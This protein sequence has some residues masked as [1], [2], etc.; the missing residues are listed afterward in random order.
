MKLLTWNIQWGCG[1]DGRVDLE[2]IV[3]TARGVADFD[4]FC[5]QEV[6]DNGSCKS[7]AGAQGFD[8]VVTR[9]FKDLASGAEIRRENFQTHY[10]AEPIIRCIPPAAPAAPTPGG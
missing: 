5:V 10:A 4:V 7:Q 6:A 1:T 2:R 3:R 8:I 9:V